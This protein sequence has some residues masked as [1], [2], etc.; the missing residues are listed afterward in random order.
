[1]TTLRKQFKDLLLN[2]EKE[3]LDFL[4]E[5]ANKYPWCDRHKNEKHYKFIDFACDICDEYGLNGLI[6]FQESCFDELGYKCHNEREEI[7]FQDLLYA[8]I[9]WLSYSKNEKHYKVLAK[10]NDIEHDFTKV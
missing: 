7:I 8:L 6:Q 3:D 1:M 5:I 2:L 9:G 4:L 10:I